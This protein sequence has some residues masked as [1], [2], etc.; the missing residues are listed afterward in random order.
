M[1][2]GVAPLLRLLRL[3]VQDEHLAF[4]RVI[5]WFVA[6]ITS[7]GCGA[8]VVLLQAGCGYSMRHGRYPVPTLTSHSWL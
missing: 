1:L 5:S 4:R 3:S 2:I 6:V 8:D 7:R